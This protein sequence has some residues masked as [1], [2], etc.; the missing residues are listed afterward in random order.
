MDELHER[1]ANCR[2]WSRVNWC[3]PDGYPLGECRRYP[4]TR[5]DEQAVLARHWPE[6][7]DRDWCGE[8]DQ[9]ARDEQKANE[10]K[11]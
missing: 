11:A 9:K 5:R 7:K 10:G 2:W 6:T 3:L 8:F 4:P 1:C